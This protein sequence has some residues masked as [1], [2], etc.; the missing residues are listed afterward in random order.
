MKLNI[1]I[2]NKKVSLYADVKQLVEKGMNL[3]DKEWKDKFNT[4]HI[5]KKELIE[6]Q[7]KQKIEMEE[8]SKTKKN[9]IQK[10]IEE[11]RKTKELELE[12]RRR[13]EEEERKEQQKVLKIKI[14]FSVILGILTIIF[15]A[16]GFLLGNVSGDP[17]SGWYMIGILGICTG[18][19][20]GSI[21]I[22][23]NKSKK[24]KYKY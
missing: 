15:V 17:D 24:K 18:L 4:R 20:I 14:I 5:A 9:W 1:D 10:I 23:E 16:V 12:Y 6:F 19:G 2:K 21:W 13:I 11:Q 7:H 3:H 22:S 8:Q